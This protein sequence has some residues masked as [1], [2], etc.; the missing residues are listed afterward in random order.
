M[1]G[2]RYLLE[3][4]RQIEK[5]QY[6]SETSQIEL[7]WPHLELFWASEPDA[8][9]RE[10][11]T[12]VKQARHTGQE[13]KSDRHRQSRAVLAD[14]VIAPLRSS[15]IPASRVSSLPSVAVRHVGLLCRCSL[16]LFPPLSLQVS[17]GVMQK[18]NSCICSYV[19]LLCPRLK[20]ATTTRGEKV[21]SR[22][23]ERERNVGAWLGSFPER[24]NLDLWNK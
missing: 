19:R 18:T 23:R 24:S 13:G 22:E 7:T 12:A 6:V 17:H 15:P 5:L 16:F 3:F 1:V 20:D 10:P 8:P 9:S 11:R 14:H 4:G 2:K 21:W